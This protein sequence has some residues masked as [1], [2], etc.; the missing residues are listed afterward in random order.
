MLPL[1][2]GKDASE[3]VGAPP[4]KKAKMSLETLDDKLFGYLMSGPPGDR[5]E[6]LAKKLYAAELGVICDAVSR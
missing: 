4:K 5:F 6:C 1:P 2:A 3:G